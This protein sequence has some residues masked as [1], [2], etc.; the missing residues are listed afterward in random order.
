MMG[1]EN[2]NFFASEDQQQII[3]LLYLGAL[4]TLRSAY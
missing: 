2:K 3:T 4:A 1:P